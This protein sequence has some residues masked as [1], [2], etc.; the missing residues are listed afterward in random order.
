VRARLFDVE[1]KCR[2]VAVKSCNSI[3]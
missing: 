3:I 2:V 1:G